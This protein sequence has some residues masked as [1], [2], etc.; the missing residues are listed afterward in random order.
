MRKHH[1]IIAGL[2]FLMC[3]IS[4]YFG[5]RI[6]NANENHLITELNEMDKIKFDDIRKVPMLSLS[7]AIFTAPMILLMLVFEII[8]L[9]KVIHRQ[10]KNI[11]IAM[12]V[13]ICVILTFD[14]LILTNPLY[15]D[16]SKWGFIWICL[17]LIL[18]A[19]NILSYV[20]RSG[21]R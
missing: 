20:L 13:T 12:I 7:A 2:A 1:F 3:L 4:M 8:V 10:A 11:C 21:E 14:V 15:F 18:V 9:K 6:Y 16:F 17:G 19:A 5:M